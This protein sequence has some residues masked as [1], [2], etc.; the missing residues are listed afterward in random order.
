V[1]PQSVIARCPPYDPNCVGSGGGGGGGGIIVYGTQGGCGTGYL[2]FSDGCEDDGTD[3][4]IYP[5]W[6]TFAS[7]F[8]YA[9]IHFNDSH[10]WARHLACYL[11]G[12]TNLQVDTAIDNN[13]IN[14]YY[15]SPSDPPVGGAAAQFA[16][17]Y[18]DPI[19]ATKTITYR[20]RHMGEFPSGTLTVDT[21]V[22]GT[23]FIRGLPDCPMV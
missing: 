9:S 23:A 15:K 20:I 6:D 10:F 17:Q 1:N 21:Y 7:I 14:V 4:A 16:F 18:V 3:P 8:N 2:Y 11:T 5:Q 19:T 12:S 13:F 22:V